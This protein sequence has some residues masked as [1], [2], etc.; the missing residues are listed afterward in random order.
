MFCVGCM[1][2]TTARKFLG[3]DHWL[4][5]PVVLGATLRFVHPIDD[6]A[7]YTAAVHSML[8]NPLN[9]LFASFDP[10]GIVMVDKPP[11]S[12]WLQAGFSW[13]VNVDQWSIMFPQLV[14]GT[15]AIVII[16]KTIKPTF[17]L[18][19]ALGAA[20]ILAIIPASVSIDSSNEP[21]SL[22]SFLLLGTVASAIRGVRTRNWK[23]LC[24]S[25]L[26]IGLGFNTKM[27]VSFV[28]LPALLGYVFLMSQCFAKRFKIGLIASA[29]IFVVIGC[30]WLLLLVLTPTSNRPYVGSTTD[31]SIITLVFQHNG[32]NRFNSTIRTPSH[33][34]QIQ[35]VKQVNSSS[36][37][38][39]RIANNRPAS[40]GSIGPPQ[41]IVPPGS[42]Q[43][44]LF[45]LMTSSLASQLGWLLPIGLV[46]MIMLFVSG[47]TK[48]VFLRPSNYFD[49]VRSSPIASQGILWAGWLFSGVL[50]FGTAD[51]TLSHPYYL[52]G[53]AVP[54]AAV[55]GIGGSL[56]W[57]G[58]QRKPGLSWLLVSAVSFTVIYQFGWSNSSVID[59]A[60]IIGI[61]F[62]LF[63]MAIL[64]VGAWEG[65]YDSPLF[66][67]AY[68]LMCASILFIPLGQSVSQST[69]NSS[70]NKNVPNLIR[71]QDN[72]Q[73]NVPF[74]NIS[75]FLKEQGELPEEIVL[76]TVRA[77]EAAPFIVS[78]I[79]TIA[80]GG[81]SGNDPI[82]SID[83]FHK[84]TT[85]RGPKYFFI[86]TLEMRP[87]RGLL[88]M[89]TEI[90][91]SIRFGWDDISLLVELP[92]G[93]LYRRSE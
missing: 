93:T 86:P 47:L 20:F 13:M 21:D 72:R 78:G 54:L 48:E 66:K 75:Q 29:V 45:S 24:V 25:A 76:G 64:M 19:A 60:L 77:K 74:E 46:A 82:F 11:L 23:W 58:V 18:G 90:V 28:P 36:T 4:L 44:P 55:L 40:S 91:E 6:N 56:M 31:N 7:Y 9:F 70:F 14:V 12:F 57:A 42:N 59:L 53:L 50:I 63:G 41:V 34:P 71:T 87:V 10:L 22:L 5:L 37:L 84:M 69:Q 89:N 15:L 85:V 61:L 27:L 68:L 83:S 92:I 32:L 30:G 1:I 67:S 3:T 17:G 2:L 51:A 80:I 33:L 65:V 16:F 26:L 52:V 39:D 38:D 35:T 8:Q 49:V 88:S 81:F 43:L 79:P 73:I 62:Y